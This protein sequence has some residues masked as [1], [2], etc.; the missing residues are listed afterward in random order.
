MDLQAFSSGVDSRKMFK[1]CEGRIAAPEPAP[2]TEASTNPFAEEG[3][4]DEAGGGEDDEVIL[5]Q[6]RTLREAK[7]LLPATRSHCCRRSATAAAAQPLLLPLNHR[8]CCRSL[9]TLLPLAAAG[10][11]APLRQELRVCVRERV[12]L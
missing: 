4:E 2:A 11:V 6:V 10:R 12:V 9:L 7:P 5:S 1:R 3:D 8:C